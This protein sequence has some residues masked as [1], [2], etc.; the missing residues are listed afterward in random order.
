MHF[1]EDVHGGGDLSV[2]YQIQRRD[3]HHMSGVDALFI[4]EL[5]I[6][7]NE[8]LEYN[9]D[10]SLACYTLNNRWSPYYHPQLVSVRFKTD[11]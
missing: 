8:L 10:V 9:S 2:I 1:I 3:R 5:R 7:K 11:G 6:H 4:L